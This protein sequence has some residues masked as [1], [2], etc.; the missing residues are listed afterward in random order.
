MRFNRS[1]RLDTGQVRDRRRSGGGR[2]PGGK[3]GAAGGGLGLVG[4]IVVVVLTALGGGDA[5]SMLSGGTL[6]DILAGGTGGSASA[7]NTEL[8]ESCRTGA[9]AN[10]T[11][12]CAVVA[13]VN[14]IQSTWT[15]AFAAGDGVYRQA[16]TV[17]YTGTTPTACGTG[18]ASMGPFYCPGDETVYIDLS[19]WTELE[20]AFGADASTFSQAYVLAHEYGHHVQHLIG[21]MAD[22]RS[23][24]GADSDAVRLELQADCYAGVWAHHAS[25]TPGPDGAVLIEDITEAD[26]A[27]A[28]DTA[29][30]IGDDYIQAHL[31]GRDPDPD[32]FTHGSSAQRQRWFTAGL[33]TGDPGRCDTFGAASLG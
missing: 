9:D 30:R 6:G 19:F 24:T 1:S 16:P 4:V 22:V 8:E 28:V 13:I 23:R 15:E 7:D 3:I 5:G 10:A 29:G 26:I 11:D 17:F 31:G 12:D 14:S 33:D 20:T 2:I 27:N 32:S 21:T 18:S 25:T